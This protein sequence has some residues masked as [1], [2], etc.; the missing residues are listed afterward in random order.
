VREKFGGDAAA[1]STKVSS[2]EADSEAVEVVG[3]NRHRKLR[4][5]DL[6]KFEKIK[7]EALG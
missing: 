4:K 7:E 2:T 5:A 3:V 1:L 6:Q